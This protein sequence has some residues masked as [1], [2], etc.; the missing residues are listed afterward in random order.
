MVRKMYCAFSIDS[1]RSDMNGVWIAS[2]IIPSRQSFWFVR[3]VTM[4]NSAS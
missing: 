1:A 2:V 3:I 4:L